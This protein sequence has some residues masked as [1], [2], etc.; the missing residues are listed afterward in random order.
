M[1]FSSLLRT[2]RMQRLEWRGG[3]AVQKSRFDGLFGQCA[4]PA[5]PAP[6]R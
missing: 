2:N 3:E 6:M 5:S 4:L 1:G